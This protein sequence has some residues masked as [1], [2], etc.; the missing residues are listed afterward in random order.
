M[1][2]KRS[3]NKAVSARATT[4]PSRPA[5]RTPAPPR[6]APE[7][8]ERAQNTSS[9]NLLLGALIVASAFLAWYYHGL[10]L[11]QMR[12]LVNGLVM[13]DHLFLGYGQDKVDALRE[14][15]DS[16]ARGQLSWV[17]KTAGT[18]FSVFTALAT[19]VSIGMHAPRRPWRRVLYVA[20]A[21][22]VLV[23][24][25]QNIVVDQM[26]GATGPELVSWA[27]TLT[28]TGWVLL[29]VCVLLVVVVLVSAFVREFRRRWA[30]PSLQQG[31]RRSR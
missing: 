4:Q 17:H 15:M 28:V 1:S 8:G 25:A 23:A 6:N 3:K 22:F 31:T 5:G 19:A 21:L 24:I 11:H 30:D 14:A 20:P 29:L 18:L 13:P 2:S 9:P 16:D 10:A 7:S 27:S 26:L 12:D